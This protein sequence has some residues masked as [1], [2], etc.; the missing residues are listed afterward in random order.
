MMSTEDQ[1]DAESFNTLSSLH[2]CINTSI[3]ISKN[4]NLICLVDSPATHANVIAEAV[5]ASLQKHSS[6]NCGIPMI[7]GNG[8]PRPLKIEV[9]AGMVVDGMGNVVGN[10]KVIDEVLRQRCEM[11]RQHLRRSREDDGGRLDSEPQPSP[12]RRRSE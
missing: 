10:E 5:S 7:D 9:D 11:S 12:K 4:N 6:G 3:N 8:N 1:D 2:L